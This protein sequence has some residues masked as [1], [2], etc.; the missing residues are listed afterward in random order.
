MLALIEK[1]V[2]F[3]KVKVRRINVPIPWKFWLSATAYCGE[4]K[5]W[6]HYWFKTG[7]AG[8]M[9]M[10]ILLSRKKHSIPS[11]FLEIACCF[12]T[13]KPMYLISRNADCEQ[14]KIRH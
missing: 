13:S 9:C 2:F 1:C 4:E 10:K 5:L 8:E 14:K 11:V 3:C 7:C 6:H 12:S